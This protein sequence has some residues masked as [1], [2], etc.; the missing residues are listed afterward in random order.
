MK[1]VRFFAVLCCVVAVFAACEKDENKNMVENF[2]ATG[3]E[4]GYNY[5]GLGLSVKW[6]TC[7]VG[8]TEPHKAG[9][10]YA[11]GET[12]PKDS[13]S[14]D[15]YKYGAGYGKLTKYNT[16]SKCGVVD[17]KTILEA[18]DDAA[19][20]NLGGAWR[21][22]TDAEWTEL[23]NNCTWTYT[24]DYNNTGVA[25]YKIMGKNGNAI[26]LPSVGY[27]WGSGVFHSLNDGSYWSSSLST[28]GAD[29]AWGC[30]FLSP[31]IARRLDRYFG[32]A[33]RPV[34]N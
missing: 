22:P 6:A 1:K 27:R 5:V 2:T 12:A 13:Y 10:Y 4:N 9:N 25:G 18:D 8:A 32:A 21:M 29:F 31:R 11:W 28:E 34:C 19:T 23:I 14:W 24:Y 15:T 30:F 26:F 17:G 16:D 20:V 3:S 33:I 7:N